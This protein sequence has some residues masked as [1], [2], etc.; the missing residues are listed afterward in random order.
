MFS[1]VIS[2]KKTFYLITATTTLTAFL[3]G[4]SISAQVHVNSSA[5]NSLGP[6]QKHTTQTRAKTH[7]KPSSVHNKNHKPTASSPPHKNHPNSQVQGAIP[8]IPNAP[9]PIPV[10]HDPELNVPLHPPAPPP[11]PKIVPNAPGNAI[12]GQH[13]VL[14]N[15]VK[16]SID[17]NEGMMKATM[18]FANTAKQNPKMQVYLN[19]YSHGTPDDISTPRRTALNRGLAIRA[20]LINQ[21]I[22]STRIYLI[23]KGIPAN[24]F[25]G[26]PDYV[27]MILS[28]SVPK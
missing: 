21:G 4:P 13:R 17:L 26:N 8:S 23:T 25:K 24:D 10:F 28:D 9:P 15:F 11:M 18:E 14:I 7:K 22:P 19:A 6:Q 20:V 3:W 1:S 27:E 5:L 16:D 12:V 2:I